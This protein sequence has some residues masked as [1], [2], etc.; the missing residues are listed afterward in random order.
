M[1]S[2]LTWLGQLGFALRVDGQLTLMDP[3]LTDH[4]DRTRPP[5]DESPYVDGVHSVLVSHEHEDHF[6][7]EFV[8][9]VAEANPGMRLVL[10]REV[11]A[12][13]V[14]M[15]GSDRV[16]PAA[17]GEACELGV[18]RVEPVRADHMMTGAEPEPGYLGYVVELPSGATIYHA[19]DCIVT[20]AVLAGLAGKRVDI[21]LLPINGRDYFREKRDLVGN[22]TS[23]EAVE[24][25]QWLGA[26]FLV[27][28]HWDAD[29]GNTERPGTVPEYAWEVDSPVHTLVLARGVPFSLD[30]LS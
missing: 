18:L 10:P 26:K 6:D 13:A 14:E 8:A 1:T 9:K 16:I 28:S 25:A 12:E 20:D 27:P 5:L 4:P 22:M 23:R 29:T 15:L 3:W 2:T 7:R 21:A 17:P 11:A 30:G 19:G 24:F